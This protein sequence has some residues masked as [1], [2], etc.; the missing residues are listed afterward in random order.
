ML[1][2]AGAVQDSHLASH[3]IW[4]LSSRHAKHLGAQG[5]GLKQESQGDIGYWFIETFTFVK[6]TL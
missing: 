5:I 1:T 6:G 3:F 2:V 4:P